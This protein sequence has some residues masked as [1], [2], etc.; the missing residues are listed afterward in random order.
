MTPLFNSKGILR[1]TLALLVF[2]SSS[3]LTAP[4]TSD[5]PAEFHGIAIH[6]QAKLCQ[7]FDDGKPASMVYHVDALPSETL[8]FYTT[9]ATLEVE[10]SVSG[11]TLLLSSDKRSRVVIS[12]DGT[13]SQID[14]LAL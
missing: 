11:R 5:C 6:Q 14:L 2:A 12:A 1:T 4:V 10:S 8:D 13:G 7:I 3:A 9:Q